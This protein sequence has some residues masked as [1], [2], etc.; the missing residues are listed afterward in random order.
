MRVVTR[1]TFLTLPDG[2][3][4]CKGKPWAF[5]ELAV[6]TASRIG[7]GNDLGDFCY[8]SF[9]DIPCADSG[10]YIDRLEM[11]LNEGKSYPLELDSSS[12]DGCFDNDDI[13]LVYDYEDIVRLRDYLSDILIGH[14][15]ADT[16]S[17]I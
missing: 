13:F 4:F 9:R 6:K 1:K 16:F 2:T 12:R 17:P 11:M 15:E 8:Q 5:E 7:E 3:L 14:N 10:E